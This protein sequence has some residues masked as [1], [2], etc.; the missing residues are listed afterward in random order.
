[1]LYI[2]FINSM[3]IIIIII[4]IIIWHMRVLH[5][6]QVSSIHSCEANRTSSIIARLPA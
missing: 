6:E 1:V 3:I 4:I 5:I 2:V